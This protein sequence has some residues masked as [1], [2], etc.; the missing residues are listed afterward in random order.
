MASKPKKWQMQSEAS[1]QS[2]GSTN[3]WRTGACE[4]FHAWSECGSITITRLLLLAR[5]LFKNTEP[6]T[7]GKVYLIEERDGLSIVRC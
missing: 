3:K 5:F 2:N 4:T 7:G 1:G 6:F